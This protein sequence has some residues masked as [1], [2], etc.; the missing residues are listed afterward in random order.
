MTSWALGNILKDVVEKEAQRQDTGKEISPYPFSLNRSKWAG[1][2][3]GTVEVGAARASEII[4]MSNL[5]KVLIPLTWKRES[6][7]TFDNQTG[8][9]QHIMPSWP[10][11][12]R[13]KELPPITR[14]WDILPY[15]SP[16][17]R[18]Q[19]ECLPL[20]P[21][22]LP[23]MF[24]APPTEPAHSYVRL[25]SILVQGKPLKSDSPT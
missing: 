17:N 6:E 18:R 3:Q 13:V 25:P 20:L 8:P 16:G 11:T 21:P 2:S 15:L 24:S 4:I 23:H 5:A 10:S 9:L 7:K 1:E 22:N 12:W 14:S 19:R